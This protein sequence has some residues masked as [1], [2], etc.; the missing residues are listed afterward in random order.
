MGHNN[1]KSSYEA[2]WE[3]LSSPE[4]LLR[5]LGRE[6][7]HLPSTGCASPCNRSSLGYKTE[8][9]ELTKLRKH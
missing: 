9:L 1:L 5:P 6:E 8:L 3:S 4:L 2:V 7:F